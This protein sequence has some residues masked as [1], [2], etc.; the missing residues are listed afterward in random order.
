MG[1]TTTAKFVG[2][3]MAYESFKPVL[4]KRMWVAAAL[5]WILF[6][7]C[8]GFSLLLQSDKMLQYSEGILRFM[9]HGGAIAAALLAWL[10]CLS[11]KDDLVMKRALKKF[12]SHMTRLGAAEAKLRTALDAMLLVDTDM[13]RVKEE[14]KEAQRQSEAQLSRIRAMQCSA[15]QSEKRTT[16]EHAILK[17]VKGSQSDD[18]T[19]DAEDRM[20]IFLLIERM[21]GHSQSELQLLREALMAAPSYA[22]PRREMLDIL[23]RLEAFEIVMGVDV[24]ED[25]DEAIYSEI[26][27]ELQGVSKKELIE[28]AEQAATR[29]KRLEPSLG[30][31][32]EIVGVVSMAAMAFE[33][34]VQGAVADVAE[35]VGE[36]GSDIGAELERVHR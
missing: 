24:D 23:L 35:A 36:I 16:V 17:L 12:K 11:K 31:L 34:A 7:I 15:M 2:L 5:S 29:N 9:R 25:P 18:D 20:K 1:V 28:R 27:V 19:F 30:Q 32:K 33:G 8:A 4:L 6:L 26:S 3:Y 13:D 22:V 14:I 10:T 21:S